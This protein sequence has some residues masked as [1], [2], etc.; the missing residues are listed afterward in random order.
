MTKR[1][2]LG[3]ISAALKNVDEANLRLYRAINEAREAGI[4]WR[5]LGAGTGRSHEF[6]RAFQARWAERAKPAKKRRV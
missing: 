3:D 2:Y 6:F 1:N 5:E 4:S